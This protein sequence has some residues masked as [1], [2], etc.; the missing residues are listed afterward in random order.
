MYN[1]SYNSALEKFE[2]WTHNITE[3]V[4]GKIIQKNYT[5]VYAN[6]NYDKN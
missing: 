6:N 5:S 3:I 1:I 2:F 4:S